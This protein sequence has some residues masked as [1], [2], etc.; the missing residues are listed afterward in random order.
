MRAASC[1][2]L[3]LAMVSALWLS[4]AGLF[5]CAVGFVLGGGFTPAVAS[6]PAFAILLGV[7]H[8]VAGWAQDRW[9]DLFEFKRLH[10]SA[11]ASLGFVAGWGAVFGF[12]I[13]NRASGSETNWLLWA[14]PTLGCLAGLAAVFA[15][16]RR[17][18]T[19]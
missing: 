4:T 11:A 14:L 19:L 12:G 6:I 16:P 3:A 7:A 17:A 18:R 2:K 9:N 5:G 8:S 10:L 13:P 1:I 15:W